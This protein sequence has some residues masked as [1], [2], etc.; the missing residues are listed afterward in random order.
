MNK[1]YKNT[2][3]LF[4]TILIF[5]TVYRF[6]FRFP[7]WIDEFL[8]KPLLM[9]VPVLILTFKIEKKSL[10]SIGI[11]NRNLIKNIL[12]GL[13]AGIFIS[14]EA[15]LTNNLKNNSISFNPDNISGLPLLITVFVPF[16]T[17]VVEEIVFRGYIMNRL[18]QSISNEFSAIFLSTILFVVLHFPMFIFIEQLSTFDFLTSSI[19]L[20]VLGA[21]NG[22]LFARTRTIIAPTISHG[23]WNLSTVLFR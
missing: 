22:F 23:L 1:N 12:I 17:G 4:L 18:W 11:S 10:E 9:L 6:L 21:F 7:E 20:F 15:I 2:L 14:L 19:Q 5:W 3:L 13:A 16:A 8:F